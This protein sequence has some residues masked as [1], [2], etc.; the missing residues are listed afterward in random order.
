MS[1][2]IQ[3]ESLRDIKTCLVVVAHPDDETLWSGGTILMN[4]QVR[5]TII[6]I[7]RKSDAER[8]GKFY[9]ALEVLKA[10][11]AMGDLDDGPEQNPLDNAR[12]QAEIISLL[13]DNHFDLI[14][15]H[16]PR[17]EYTRHLRHEET[18]EAVTALRKNGEITAKQ[19]WQFAYEDGNGQYLPRNAPDADITNNLPE[20]IWQKKYDIITKIYGFTPD[21]FEAKTTLFWCLSHSKQLKNPFRSRKK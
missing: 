1:C 18:A 8:A 10:K 16:S 3:P 19:L 9:K 2:T 6:T 12:I 11:G 4:P 7:C 15:T 14:I 20:E 13:P 5:W 21:S 17:G